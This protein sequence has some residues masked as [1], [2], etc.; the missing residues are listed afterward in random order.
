[1]HLQNDC[2]VDD[3]SRSGIDVKKAIKCAVD[4]ASGSLRKKQAVD[5]KA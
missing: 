1:M 4:I 2:E 5:S 3:F